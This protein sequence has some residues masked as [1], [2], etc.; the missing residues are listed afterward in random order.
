VL[1]IEVKEISLEVPEATVMV[2]MDS[3]DGTDGAMPN[4][5]EAIIP[6]DWH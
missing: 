3:K 1:G 2:S 5:L 4:L 6:S